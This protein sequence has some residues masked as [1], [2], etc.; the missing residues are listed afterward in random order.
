MRSKAPK[1]KEWSEGL[2]NK[3]VEFHGHGGPFMVIGLR[4]G[5]IALQ[6]LDVFG[7]FDLKC[8]LRL[9]WNPPDSCVI[10]GIQCST[11]CTMGKNNIIIKEGKGIEAEFQKNDQNLKIT[12]KSEVLNRIRKVLSI[13]QEE[14]INVLIKKLVEATDDEIFIT[15]VHSS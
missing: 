3:A 9:H 14:P 2:F 13:G 8:R 6:R 11:G 10:D 4:M 7:W 15:T 12:L 1:Q 5:L